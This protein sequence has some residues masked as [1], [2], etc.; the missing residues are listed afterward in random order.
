MAADDRDSRGDDARPS[1]ERLTALADGALEPDAAAPRPASSGAPAAGARIATLPKIALSYD[2][3]V[4]CLSTSGLLTSEELA[5]LRNSLPPEAVANVDTLASHLLQANKLTLYQLRRVGQGNSAGLV[6]GNYVVLDELGAGGMGVVY[7]ARHRRMK[8]LVALKVLPANLISSNSAITRFHREV[9]A[10]AKLSHPNIVQAYD[11]DEASEIHFLVM[12]YVDGIDLDSYVEKCEI[13]PI[14]LALDFIAQA[15]RGLAHAHER[16][17]IH[18]DI[19]PSN[20]LLDHSGTIK[21]LDMGLARIEHSDPESD[22]RNLTQS[23]RVMGTVDFMAPEQALDAKRADHR[24]DIYSLG[25]TLHFL[26][27]GQ[28]LSPEGSLAM[29]LLWH[30]NTPVPS[31]RIDVP[32]ASKRLDALFQRMLAKRP[33]DRPQSVD[34]VLVELQACQAEVGPVTPAQRVERLGQLRRTPTD[35]V[36]GGRFGQTAAKSGDPSPETIG[37]TRAEVPSPIRRAHNPVGGYSTRNPWATLGAVAAILVAGGLGWGAY[38]LGMISGTPADKGPVANA[39]VPVPTTTAEVPD[40]PVATTPRPESPERQLLPWVLG[41]GG[42]AKIHAGD[43]ATR[44]EI[45]TPELMPTG[46]FTLVEI[47]LAGL[48]LSADDLAQLGGPAGR[49]LDTLSLAGTSTGDVELAR[50]PPLPALATLD[51]SGTRI[52][53][54]GLR[55]LVALS[56]L[57][58]LNLSRT[59]VTTAGLA[60]LRPLTKLTH[61]Y[62][63]DTRVD[64]AAAVPLAEIAGLAHVGLAGTSITADGI[65]RLK[66]ARPAIEIEWDAP[67]PDRELARRV[68]A[69]GGILT[70]QPRRPGAEA[71]AVTKTSDLPT[72]DFRVTQVDL[73]SSREVDDALVAELATLPGLTLLRLESPQITSAAVDS[74][75]S[76][77]QLAAL[78]LGAV[79]LPDEAVAALREKLPNCDIRWQAVNQRKLAQWVLEQGGTVSLVTADGQRLDEL[80]N[81]NDLPLGPF[82]LRAIDLTKLAK[83]TDDDLRQAAGLTELE[84]LRLAETGLTDAGLNHIAA[85][86]SLRELD[87]SKTA[88]TDRGLASLATLAA[89]EQLYLTDTAIGNAGV[90]ELRRLERLSHL[91]LAG[92]Q[93]TG[94][95]IDDLARM[96][97]L[98][99]LSLA[100]LPL[101]DAGIA[102]FSRSSQ[103][104]E[105]SVEGTSLTDAGLEELRAALP[106][107]KLTGDPP[108][109]QRLVARRVL[110]QGGA[111]KLAD[112]TL[113]DRT[114]N[115]PRDACTVVAVDLKGASRLKSDDF[116]RL[117]LFKSLIELDLTDTRT[118]DRDLAAL[119][120]L[121]ELR[122]LKLSGTRV[123]DQGLSSLAPL[124]ALQILDLSETTVTGSGLD[125]IVSHPQLW[126]LSLREARISDQA[127]ATI[128][129][130]PS[131][132]YLDLG[133]N[134]DLT[135]TGVASL[136]DLKDLEVLSV[137]RTRLTDAG[138]S[139]ISGLEKLRSLDVSGTQL[140]DAGTAQL[141][142]LKQLTKLS[143]AQTGITEASVD[144]LAQ[145][146]TLR[147]LDL[148]SNKLTPDG[149]AR[150]RAALPE[151]RIKP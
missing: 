78:D 131:L 94:A 100:R 61:L 143:L 35:T 126:A 7:L 15:A 65:A 151:C 138:L 142:A 44:V 129:K 139:A 27:S 26:L 137:S 75:A 12:E 95:A 87:I 113:I 24:A 111:I 118:S 140:S 79:E 96:P 134:L 102:G 25:C 50:L 33:E 5:L 97:A 29:K 127:L 28:T 42:R 81:R 144:T 41:Q 85:A 141:A 66:A 47:D 98:R 115:L 34:A 107:C 60:T 119:E 110:E 83:I 52:T 80:H 38:Q 109:P 99:W 149:L 73:V 48:P 77:T 21:I 36:V 114:M 148:T 120:S 130:L 122:S 51:L 89:L 121:G 135:D 147:E 58:E 46:N 43:H 124:T 104:V 106:N 136:A 92:T 6:L 56:N 108:D 88:I 13:L 17:I 37:P 93:V 62:L 49:S 72:D 74:L 59:A 9:E 57:R 82:R 125:A 55:A 30:Q 45:A 76:A 84:S 18:R 40:V 10:A 150:L 54:A 1:H 23:G 2:R 91:S 39:P 146:P 3:F 20:L 14:P 68:L 63:A 70:I 133:Y 4:E 117:A 90:R 103:L 22:H 69:L 31:L 16:G 112:D 86:K 132:T 64:D 67:D 145:W 105:L 32:Y 11:A 116:E 128:G 101:D 123:T 71:V 53:D 8:R 19:K